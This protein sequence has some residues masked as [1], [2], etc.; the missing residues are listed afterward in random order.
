[1]EVSGK[2]G[3]LTRNLAN[4]IILGLLIRYTVPGRKRQMEYGCHEGHICSM[5]ELSEWTI[6]ITSIKQAQEPKI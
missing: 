3:L 1:M 5:W 4:V 6:R 2:I